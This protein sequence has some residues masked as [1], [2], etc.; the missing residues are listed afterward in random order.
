MRI[1]GKKKARLL[2][3]TLIGILIIAV[4]KPFVISLDRRILDERIRGLYG[5]Y[6]A[7]EKWELAPRIP[8]N[9]NYMWLDSRGGI[10]KIGHALGS[11]GTEMANQLG[12]LSAARKAGLNVLEVDLWLDDLGNLRCFHGPGDPGPVTAKS[13]TLAERNAIA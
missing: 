7:N 6:F 13:C 5:R 8:V 12:A 11:S 1:Y 2:G 10:I 4:A 9:M 3:I